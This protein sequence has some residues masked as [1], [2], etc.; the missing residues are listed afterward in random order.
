MKRDMGRASATDRHWYTINK[1]SPTSDDVTEILIYDE[2]GDSWW[3]GVSAKEFAKDLKAIDSAAINVRLN[4][5]GGDVHDGIAILNALRAHSAK[6]TV[7]VDGLAAS[8]ASFIA[9]GGDEVVMGRNSEMMIHDAWS[10]CAGNAADMQKKAADLDRA[11]DNIASIYA[12]K[13]GGT[14]EDWREV[15]R[16]ETWY[17]AQE[18][19]DAGLADRVDAKAASGDGDAAQKNAFD[20]SIFNYAGRRAAPAPTRLPADRGAAKAGASTL[21]NSTRKEKLKMAFTDDQVAEIRDAL[22]LADD[23]TDQ[24]VFDAA[25]EELTAPAEGPEPEVE[26]APSASL[27][28][29][30]VA[31][32]SSILEGLR[33]DAARGA[34]ARTQQELDHR[35]SLLDAA[36]GDGRIPPARRAHWLTNFEADPEGAA[37]ALK[38]LAPGLIP[39]TE[40]GHGKA[41]VTDSLSTITTSD[42]YKNW[43]F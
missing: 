41:E 30:V 2:I 32:E 9:M 36:V 20:L 5:P 24:E 19:V 13:S 22:E 18:A 15:M 27:P 16:A 29:G 37:A 33:R 6:I 7:I 28:D 8:A 23:A 43:S 14:S 17:S 38:S 35:N 42:T 3:G 11:S 12:E 10:F 34:E 1:A 31:V 40:M 39:V 21:A 4:S 25:L 26:S